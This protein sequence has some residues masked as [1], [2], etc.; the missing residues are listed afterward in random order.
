MSDFTHNFWS[1]YVAGLTVVGILGCLLLLWITARKK[2]APSTDN[3]TGHVWDEDLREMD[4]PMP[5][6]W[7]W[8][9]VL[10]I[11]FGF[12]YL[13]VYPGLGRFAG[14][15][16]WTQAGEYEAEM[17]KAR[18]ELAPLYARFAAMKTEEMAAN[19]EAMAIGERLFMNNCAQCHGSDARGSKGFPNLADNDWLH[20]GAPENIRETLEK[21]RM[22]TMPP[23]AAAV[24]SPEDI[25]NLAHYVLSLSGSPHDSLR[26]S[27]G[28]SKFTAC[29]ACHGMDG[30]GNTA[31]GAPNLTDDVWLHGWGEAAITAMVNH[32]KVNVMPAQA[33][34]LTEAQIGVLTAYVWGL[35]H[36]ANAVR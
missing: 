4:N 34:K 16:G 24:G 5:R 3:T 22:G 7:M 1:V 17:A 14:Q 6:W 18:T 20:G 15:F 12:G 36:R 9:F 26:A 29:A 30:K 35:S 33:D 8:L 10:T 32:G 28:K 19:P 27:L 2:V 31:L 23:M 13:A 25:R 21:G 11:V